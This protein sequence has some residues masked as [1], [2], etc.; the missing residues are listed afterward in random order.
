MT[1]LD[2]WRLFRFAMETRPTETPKREKLKC[3]SYNPSLVIVKENQIKTGANN[4][5]KKEKQTYNYRN[6]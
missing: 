6:L 5:K 3:V 2:K 4:K 1:A